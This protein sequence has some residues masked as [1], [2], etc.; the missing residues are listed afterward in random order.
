MVK[1]IVVFEIRISPNARQT[2]RTKRTGLE[3]QFSKLF[4]MSGVSKET[5]ESEYQTVSETFETSH[6]VL[7]RTQ[8]ALSNKGI[9]K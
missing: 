8:E 9:I 3:H 5:L 1:S 4:Q 7:A 2:E 6:R